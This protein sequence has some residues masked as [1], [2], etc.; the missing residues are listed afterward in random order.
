MGPGRGQRR[1]SREGELALADGQ[2]VAR[3]P[4]AGNVVAVPGQGT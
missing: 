2:L 4:R 3:G 1:L